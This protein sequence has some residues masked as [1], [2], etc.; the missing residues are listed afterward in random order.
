[1]MQLIFLAIMMSAVGM[2]NL[3]SA[4]QPLADQPSLQIP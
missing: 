3:S 1:M 4:A 2:A